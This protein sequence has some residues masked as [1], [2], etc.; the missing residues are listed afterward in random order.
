MG[1]RK[2]EWVVWIEAVHSKRVEGSLGDNKESRSGHLGGKITRGHQVFDN[3]L[4]QDLVISFQERVDENFTVSY[5]LS[6]VTDSERV[7]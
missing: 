2:L 3:I 7:R 6:S 1:M 4:S 5:V